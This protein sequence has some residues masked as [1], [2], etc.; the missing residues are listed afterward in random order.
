MQ[1]CYLIGDELVVNYEKITGGYSDIDY[2]INITRGYN[3][4]PKFKLSLIKY[5]FGNMLT[6]IFTSYIKSNFAIILIA[7]VYGLS[8]YKMHKNL[9]NK[10]KHHNEKQ[11]QEKRIVEA[12]IS[13][14]EE[15]AL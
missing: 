12:L 5:G 15:A 11:L 7:L 2:F 14:L 13:S 1:I 4:L 9:K 6:I 3:L 10:V 8:F